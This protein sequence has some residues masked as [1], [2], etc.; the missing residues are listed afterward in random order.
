MEKGY[1]LSPKVVAHRSVPK[2]VHVFHI[3]LSRGLR[4]WNKTAEH[5]LPPVQDWAL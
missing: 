2:L 5:A 4:F 3:A 1:S